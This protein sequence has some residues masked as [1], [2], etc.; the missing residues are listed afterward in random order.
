MENSVTRR[1]FFA[2][3]PE[4]TERE[5]I[6]ARRHLIAGASKRQVPDH[7]LHLTLLFL[8]DQPADRVGDICA[9]ADMVRRSVFALKLDRFGWFSRARVVWLGGAANAPARNLVDDLTRAVRER[10]FVF[11]AREFLPHITLFRRVTQTPEFPDPPEMSWPIRGFS[12]VESIP[13][14]P[15]QVLR[16]WP[17]TL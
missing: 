5:Q 3:W 17:L 11:D 1:L 8:G 9:A 2:C 13:A 4:P 12:L 14:R 6:I 15:Y 10:D 16:T 7:N